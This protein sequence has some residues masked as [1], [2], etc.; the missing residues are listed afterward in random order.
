MDY[1]SVNFSLNSLPYTVIPCT[2][3][4]LIAD[5]IIDSGV[6]R[7]A[8]L[9]SRNGEK[10][11]F[12][13]AEALQGYDREK[14][15]GLLTSALKAEGAQGDAHFLLG[16]LDVEEGAY[17]TAVEHLTKA[18]EDAE[19]C[20]G[21]I[22]RFLPSLR[23]MARV[24][25]FHF[26]QVYPDYYGASLLLLVA[27]GRLGRIEEMRNVYDELVKL[28]KPRDELRVVMAETYIA[29]GD[30]ETALE[31]LKR[32]EIKSN[33]QLDSTVNILNGIC[34]LEL[35]KH[36][37]SAIMLKMEAVSA[38]VKNPYL[39]AIAGF[40]YSI[41]L[42][43]DGLVV[44]ALQESTQ[45]DLSKVLNPGIREFI[46]WREE[47]L[48]ERISGMTLEQVY[49]AGRLKW[50]KDEELGEDERLRIEDRLKKLMPEYWRTVKSGAVDVQVETEKGMRSVDKLFRD[51]KRRDDTLGESVVEYGKALGGVSDSEA[52]GEP[53]PSSVEPPFDLERVYPWSISQEGEREVLRFDFRGTR[54]RAKVYLSGEV[55]IRKVMEYGSI[56][57]LGVLVII[58]FRACT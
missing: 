26:F 53:E 27:L 55:F 24:S 47:R 48:R 17:H 33:D 12:E 11:L 5:A 44:L 32:E 49:H 4:A 57:A 35:G 18:R 29:S 19:R 52:T 51:F 46:K 43:R 58:A 56:V 6:S 8:L 10:A 25:R 22:R 50:V 41:A 37:E 30:Y 42:E 2:Y 14:A 40:L 16:V 45:I 1:P 34:L 9:I 13:S 54:D 20:G 21:L 15:R 23:L 38:D 28:F 39:C 3:P 31:V 36:H 7:L